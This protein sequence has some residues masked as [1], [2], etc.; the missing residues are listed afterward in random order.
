MKRRDLAI[1][2][3]A[4]LLIGVYI[5]TRTGGVNA[6][7]KNDLALRGKN[8][9]RRLN[10]RDYEACV[11][12]FDLSSDTGLD[13]ERLKNAFGPALDTLGGFVRFRSVSFSRPDRSEAGN[14]LCTI[15]CDYENAQA[16]Y[17]ILFNDRKEICGLH[18]K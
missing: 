2:A 9:V 10:R 12:A 1:A 17:S 4:A 18:L 15:K 5:G 6:T 13:A 7:L 8:F 14:I 16:V 11:T 3:A